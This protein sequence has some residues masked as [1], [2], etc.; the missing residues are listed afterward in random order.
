MKK[1]FTLVLVSAGMI[2]F[3]SA[4]TY[5][6]TKNMSNDYAHQQAYNNPSTGYVTS[7]FTYKQKEAQLS[8]INYF[9]NQR[10]ADVKHNRRLNSWEK[11]K[12]TRLLEKQQSEEISQVEIRFAKK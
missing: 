1:I 4:Q 10:I 8:K 3:A 2:S 9:F 11:S 12:Q 6:Q 5:N 7:S